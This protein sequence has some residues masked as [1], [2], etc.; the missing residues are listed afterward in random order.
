MQN[1]KVERERSKDRPPT[2]RQWSSLDCSS[3]EEE[4]EKEEEEEL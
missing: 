1:Y 3:E 4:E 2:R